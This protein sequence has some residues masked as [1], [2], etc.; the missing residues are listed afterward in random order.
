LV[1]L[2]LSH[3]TSL[4]KQ[5]LGEGA[6]IKA[7]RFAAAP[8]PFVQTYYFRSCRRQ[9]TRMSQ[10]TSYSANKVDTTTASRTFVSRAAAHAESEWRWWPRIVNSARKI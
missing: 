2:L 6:G 10:T 7:I 9:G 1:S 5:M 3:K 8:P 4:G